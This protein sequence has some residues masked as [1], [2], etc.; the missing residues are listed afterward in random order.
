[1]NSKVTKCSLQYPA[2]YEPDYIVPEKYL[3]NSR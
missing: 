2:G 1:M 3:S